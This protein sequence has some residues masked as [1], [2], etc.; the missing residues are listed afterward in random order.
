MRVYAHM[1]SRTP[2]EREK[3]KALV[4]APNLTFADPAAPET[5]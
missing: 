1:M 3:L 4:E 5:P 2:Q